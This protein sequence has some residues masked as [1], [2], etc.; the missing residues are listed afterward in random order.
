V[1]LKDAR[2]RRDEAKKLLA[3]G[4]DPGEVKKVRKAAR[5]EQAANSVEAVAR[6]WHAVKSKEWTKNTAE[7]ALASLEKDIFP[8]LGTKPV[9]EIKPK[10]VLT[11]CRRIQDRGAIETAHRAKDYISMTFRAFCKTLPQNSA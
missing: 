5:A 1:S 8:W 4:Q 10:D 7:R 3:N 2:V 11:V 9:A 6:M